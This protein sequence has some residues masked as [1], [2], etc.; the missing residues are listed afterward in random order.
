M[1]PLAAHL[2]LHL[3]R[4]CVLLPPALTPAMCR[5]YC[6]LAHLLQVLALFNKALRKLHAQLRAA[7]VAQIERTLPRPARVAT[8]LPAAAADAAAASNGGVAPLLGQGVDVSLDEEL[9]AAAAVERERL[10]AQWNPEDLAQY[11]ITGVR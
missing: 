10:R 4:V 5:E 1:L 3:H 2:H 7:K 11:V 9:D 6:R 8:A